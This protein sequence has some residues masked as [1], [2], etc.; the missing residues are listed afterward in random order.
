MTYDP[1]AP[2]FS[3]LGIIGNKKI[4]HEGH[5]FS[6]KNKENSCFSPAPR[7]G[8]EPVGARPAPNR[9]LLSKSC[10]GRPAPGAGV[11]NFVDKKVNSNKVYSVR[12]RINEFLLEFCFA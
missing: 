7:S 8:R 6:R 4:F 1:V 5:E 9:D 3:I 2:G 11:V 12:Q 10:G